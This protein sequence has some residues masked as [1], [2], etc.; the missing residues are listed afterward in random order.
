MRLGLRIAAVLVVLLL[1]ALVALAAALPRLVRSDAA[2]ARIE[3]AAREATGREIR[4]GELDFGLLPPRLVVREPEVKGATTGS[5][6]V[7]QADGV[8]LEIALAPLLAWTVVIDSI[9]IEGA[10]VRLARTT[11]GIGFAGGPLRAGA[12]AKGD[13]PP[14]PG[15]EDRESA[16]KAASPSASEPKAPSA[17]ADGGLAMAVREVSL[18]DCRVLLEDRAVSP[19]LTWEL[20]ELVADARGKSLGDPI[21]FEFRGILA[22]GGSIE[23][24]G[25]AQVEGPFRVDLQLEDVVLDP[26]EPYL[27]AGQ[28]VR[29]AASGTVSARGREWETER[30]TL[31]LLLDDGEIA[32]E[33]LAIRGQMRIHADL[34]DVL[35]AANGSFQVDATDAE[36]AYGSLLRKARGTAATATGRIVTDSDGHIGLEDTQVDVK[37]FEAEVQLKTGA[38]TRAT[39]EAEPFELAGWGAMIPALV[40]YDPSG[41]VALRDLEVATG[42][43]EVRGA[44][45]LPGLRLRGPDGAEIL[46]RGGFRGTGGEIHSKELVALLAGQEIGLSLA[47]ADLGGGRPRLS[48]EVTA[49]G[50]ESSALL[51]LFTDK[52]DALQGP[53]ELR[54]GLAGPL[55][56]GRPLAQTLRGTLRFHIQPG[57]LEGVSLLEKTFQGLG[58]VGDAALLAGRLKGGRTLQRFYEDEFQYLGGTFR[59]GDGLARSDDL[60]LEY[61]NYQVDLRGAVG[62]EDQRLD[63]RGKLTIDEEIDRA[64]ADQ[65][66]GAAGQERGGR[67]RVIPLAHVTGTLDSPRVEVTDEAVIQ[68]AA[69]YATERRREKWERKI[70][71]RLGEGTGREVLDALDQIL[72]GERREERR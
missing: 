58:T 72:S 5:D 50:V 7:F 65:G 41:E 13:A 24:S 49:E 55:G 48:A 21:G 35:E 40:D 34:A 17:D 27:A 38:R 45:D 9:V 37:N 22:S 66:E 15:T 26:A 30:L 64:I 51:G 39:V 71:E 2:R 62:L 59:I 46:L 44:V 18:H 1:I 47:L 69:L 43:L 70:D 28:S 56:A 25:E 68:F 16:R 29:G 33:E 42:P 31:D 53:L 36:L 57:R 12:P 32:A 63:L 6:P 3:A 14:S 60:R 52:K 67:S 23:A 8:E 19:A 61:R 4:Y 10:T 11:A 54:G 20:R